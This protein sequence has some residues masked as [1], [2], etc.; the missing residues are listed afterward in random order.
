MSYL[1]MGRL[2]KAHGGTGV[3]EVLDTAKNDE[4]RDHLLKQWRRVMPQWIVTSRNCTLPH[5]RH[6]E[7]LTP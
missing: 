4:Q 5:L 1:I 7:G 2:R 6:T 3:A